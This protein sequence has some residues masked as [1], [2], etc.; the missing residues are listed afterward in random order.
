MVLGPEK[1]MNAIVECFALPDAVMDSIC[2][3]A[4][5]IA[6]ADSAVLAVLAGPDLVIFGMSSNCDRL[7]SR[8]LPVEW[9]SHAQT[10]LPLSLHKATSDAQRPPRHFY[11]GR[12]FLFP[13]EDEQEVLGYLVVGFDDA[14]APEVTP[15]Q[16]LA[17][18]KLCLVASS[19]ILHETLL[20]QTARRFFSAIERDKR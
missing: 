17:L 15:H 7:A 4:R 5:E 3:I 18:E 20:A 19:Q 14:A 2:D 6:E 16:K 13:V 10:P 12:R 1:R 9:L 8:R 11:E